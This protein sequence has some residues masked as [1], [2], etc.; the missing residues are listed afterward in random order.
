T[1]FIEVE[2]FLFN[3]NGF[4]TDFILS[5]IY[6]TPLSPAVN[7]FQQRKNGLISSAD[8]AAQIALLKTHDIRRDILSHVYQNAR[9]AQYSFNLH[10]GSDN[11]SYQ[12]SAAYDEA[13]S[14][15]SATSDR[16]N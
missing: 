10:G 13:I 14:E 12:F 3:N 9:T 7:I 5:D 11:V 16:L 2:Q 1:D 4:A 6:K 15:L 8:S